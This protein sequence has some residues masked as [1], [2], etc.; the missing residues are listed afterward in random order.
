M[1]GFN[2]RVAEI[3]HGSFNWAK[4]KKNLICKVGQGT[5]IFIENKKK[6][7]FHNSLGFFG[8]ALT[9]LLLFLQASVIHQDFLRFI[10]V[11]D[12]ELIRK[13]LQPF[14]EEE[15]QVWDAQP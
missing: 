11:D 1:G 5:I 3:S 8:F 13:N 7:V 12:H 9:Y 2:N 6:S 15:E 14:P 10:H 4:G